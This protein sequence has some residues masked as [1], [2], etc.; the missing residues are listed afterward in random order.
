MNLKI[1]YKDQEFFAVISDVDIKSI[2]ASEFI[3]IK[4]AVETYGVVVIESQIIDDDDQIKFS[5]GFG[6]LEISIGTQT[7][8]PVY[9]IENGRRMAQL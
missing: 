3:Q 9:N 1:K 4:Q 5:E 2:T 7:K 6:K 8:S